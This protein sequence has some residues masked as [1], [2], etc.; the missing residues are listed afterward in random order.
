MDNEIVQPQGFQN[1]FF[2]LKGVQKLNIHI[3]L[4]YHSRMWEK[5]KHRGFK[6]GIFGTIYEAFQ[7]LSVPDVYAIKG[8]DSD[9][10]LEWNVLKMSNILDCF[11]RFKK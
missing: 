11:Q 7:Y 2:F 10:C 3:F 6:P 8:A 4:E 1:L 9:Y 5:S